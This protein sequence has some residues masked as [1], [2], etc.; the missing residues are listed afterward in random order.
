MASKIHLPKRFIPFLQQTQTDA[1]LRYGQPQAQLNSLLGST[2]HQAAESL[3]AANTANREIIGSLRASG[4][5]LDQAYTNA[6]LDAPTRAALAN[7]PT[8]AR[9][10]SELASGQ[11]GLL[12][13]LSGAQSGAV[14]QRQ[15]ILDQ[16]HQDVGQ[17]NDQAGQLA[18]EKGLFQQGELDQLISGD[19]ASRHAANQHLKDQQFTASQNEAD[20]LNSSLNTLLG[21]G[22]TA[23]VGKNGQIHIGA[24]IPGGKADPNSPQNRA[25]AQAKN[26]A[27]HSEQSK[28]ETQFGTGLQTAKALNGNGNMSAGDLADLLE[29]GNP[30]SNAKPGQPVYVKV[31]IKDKVT[32]KTTGYKYEKKIDPKTGL[33][34]TRG[35]SGARPKIPG[36]P[37]S[38]A[39]AVAEQA[40]HGFV[41]SRTIKELH[42][43]GYSVLSF[44]NLVTEMQH[45]RHPNRPSGVPPVNPYAPGS[46]TNVH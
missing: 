35:G 14:Y 4:G 46:Q 27:T 31:P 9:I 22:L 39:R 19:R 41:S 13:Q 8:G 23:S 25:Q 17:I 29:Q 30:G 1:E 38:I 44:P 5:L 2:V 32:G 24:P 3:G 7:S 40:A 34:V 20:N 21:Q 26:R 28:A 36:L 15:H 18:R 37:A 33:V 11:A 6:G 43:A 10:A 42:Q 12:Q 45:N 16:L